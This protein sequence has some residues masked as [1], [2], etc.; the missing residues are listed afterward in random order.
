M[1]LTTIRDEVIIPAEPEEI[2][3]AYVDPKKHSAFTGS[4]ATGSGKVGGEFT[5]WD[6][7]IFGK[8]LVLETGKRIVQEWMTTEWPEGYPASKL[9]L[10]LKKVKG[11]TQLSMVHSNV[12][13]EQADDYKQ[14]WTDFYW[15]PLR[16]YFKK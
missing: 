3:D 12:P 7:Y 2:Y 8:N 11:G 1:E 14:G 4:K 6:G 13:A 9:E 10:T 16:E 5:A 15:K